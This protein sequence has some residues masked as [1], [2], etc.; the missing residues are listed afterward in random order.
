MTALAQPIQS[1]LPAASSAAAERGGRVV[2]YVTDAATETALRQAAG[3]LLVSEFEVRR[4]DVRTA[5]RDLARQR[6]PDLLIVD[7]SG[8]ELPIGAMEALSQVCEPSVTVVAVGDRN[9]VALY[10]NL[11]G[12]GVAEYLFK[13]L[14]ADQVEALLGRA[15]GTAGR[16]EDTGRQGKLV[17][18]TGARGGAGTTTVAVNL[19]A[20]LADID[21]RRIA[22]VDL[23]LHT[24]TVALHLNLKPGRGLREA[25]EAPERVDGLFL[26]RAMQPASDRL[27]VLATEEPIVPP[28]AQ[29]PRA[30]LD[31]LD[32]LRGQYHYVV[33]DVPHGL[34]ETARAVLDHAALRIIVA[35][36]NLAGARDALR[37]R[38]AFE[39]SGA[40]RQ[41][42][43]VHNRRGAPGALSPADFGRAL[44]S[45]AD[46]AIECRP[47]PL[48]E[49]ATLGEPAIRRCAPFKSDISRLAG[50]VSGQSA[51]GGAGLLARL[52]RSGKAAR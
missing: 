40:A 22:L 1:S 7:L 24:G 6:S 37:L 51:N 35:D 46:C 50:A 3:Q 5:A 20:Y 8:I 23:D 13:P 25:I 38:G 43:T 49:A 32:C 42:L 9:D 19:A 2:A 28:V 52:F 36:G 47:K 16:G 27:D 12:L 11:R 14:P 30:V 17:A 26:E 18:V 34:S 48:V 33:V 45:T 4:G 39:A 31:L 15:A 44:G 29:N 41:T 21:R 10:R